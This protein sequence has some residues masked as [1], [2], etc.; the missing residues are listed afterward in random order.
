VPWDVPLSMFSSRISLTLVI[1]TN[2]T[3]LNLHTFA[4]S[5]S[6]AADVSVHVLPGVDIRTMTVGGWAAGTNINL[7]HEGF[8]RGRGGNGGSGGLADGSGPAAM[9]GQPG[10]SGGWGLFL[11]AGITLNLNMDNGYIW[12]G[13]G[14]GGGGGGSANLGNDSPGGG[15]G[16]GQG[17]NTSLGGAP[18]EG[19]YSTANPGGAGGPTGPGAGGSARGGAGGLWG[20]VGVQGSTGAGNA[21]DRPGGAGGAAGRAIVLN[22]S[23]Y[24]LTGVKT[25]AN[26]Q[27]E[28]RIIGAIS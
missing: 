13:G 3:D 21:V 15:G 9:A 5:P 19:A 12:G 8:I 27:G 26:L 6:A 24:T 10:G 18:G 16:G 2:Q 17:W 25:L 14:G 22:G 28:A 1:D 23:S 4:G 7:L 11:V 20:A